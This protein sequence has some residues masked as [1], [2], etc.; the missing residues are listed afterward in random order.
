ME[1]QVQSCGQAFSI[2]HHSLTRM[3]SGIDK[4]RESWEVS[5]KKRIYSPEIRDQY[6]P[7]TGI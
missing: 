5:S 2:V 6:P 4:C 1:S 3:W 7:S